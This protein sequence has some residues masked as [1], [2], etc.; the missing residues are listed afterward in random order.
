VSSGNGGRHHTEGQHPL[1]ARRIHKQR[2]EGH[3]EN[4]GL[5]VE[6]RDERSL[7]EVMA[8]LDVQ[9]GRSTGLGRQ[10]LE[11]QPGQVGSAQPLH[12][13]ECRRVRHQQGR[14]T[15]HRRPHQ[16]LV[17]RDHAQRGR[18]TAAHPALAGGG[19]ERQ[20]AG[21]REW[22]ETTRWRRRK[23]P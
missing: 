5:G 13:M 17:A 8:R 2:E 12:G 3:V 20:I 6:Q 14:H 4:D 22:P 16:H 21:A 9:H 7:L 19:D 10:H 18:Q 11:A 1:V 23:A 15:G